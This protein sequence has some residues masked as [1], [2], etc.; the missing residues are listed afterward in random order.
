MDMMVRKVVTPSGRGVRG[1]YPSRK[2]KKM[3]PWESL[4]ERDA[5]LLL[6]FSPGILKYSAQPAK[7]Y[8]YQNESQS[9]YY[10]DFRIDMKHDKYSHIEVKPASKLKDHVLRQRLAAIK[11]HH[12]DRLNTQFLVFDETIIRKEP[13]LTNLKLLAYHQSRQTT[14]DEIN[15]CLDKL[16]LLPAQTISAAAM[17]LGDV[18]FVYQLI[19]A[20]HYLCD[21]DK[22]LDGNTLIYPNKGEEHDAFLF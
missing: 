6:E 21:L 8:F 10:P 19:A 7:I 15:E 13:Q 20:R 4:L 2:M 11:T 9:L 17:V 22:S 1:Y 12:E 16:S 3:I 14:E 5:I 18:R